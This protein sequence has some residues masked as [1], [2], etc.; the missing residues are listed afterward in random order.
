[1]R[2]WPKLSPRRQMQFVVAP[3][4]TLL[5][6]AAVL[7]FWHDHGTS[8]PLLVG[9]A[10]GV[11]FVVSLWVAVL[12]RLR[13]R[14][15]NRRAREAVAAGHEF[16]KSPIGR[17]VVGIAVVIGVAATVLGTLG[18]GEALVV[19]VCSILFAGGGPLCAVIATKAD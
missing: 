13:G 17:G 11:I 19:G 9:C 4:C 7:I 5:G 3:F 15:G 14:F 8:T 2:L 1:M 16:P 6:I 10:I 18:G 12:T